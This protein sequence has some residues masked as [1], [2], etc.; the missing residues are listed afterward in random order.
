M[1][2]IVSLGLMFAVLAI[3]LAV[4]LYAVATVL[5]GYFY[6]S[7]IN[8]L[9]VRAIAGGMTAAAFLTA[10][11]NINIKADSK[12]KYGTL[13]EFNNTAT[14]PIQEFVAIRRYVRSTDANGKI[15]E[16]ASQPFTK[17]NTN[18]IE[19]KDPS[20]TFAMSTGDY[21]TVAIEVP[22][23]EAKIRLEAELFVPDDARPGELKAVSVADAPVNAT[24][25]R[26][27]IRV[28]REPGGRRYVEFSQLGTPGSIQAP[29]RGAFFAAIAI[30]L[31]HFA[32]WLIVFWPILRF[33]LGVS[34]GLS[35]GMGLLT[36]L[37]LMPLLFEKGRPKPI[38]AGVSIAARHFERNLKIRPELC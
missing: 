10:W 6:E 24:Y 30:N 1:G 5:H 2:A 20:R 14:T 7:P 17:L 9:P 34:L 22:E 37:F 4:L 18:Y 15:R 29:N 33:S 21:L 13:L 31:L 23:G 36:M 26:E 12:D 25:G 35:A 11:V 27:T 8:H 19:A 38:P 28:F 32:V 3:S 16:A